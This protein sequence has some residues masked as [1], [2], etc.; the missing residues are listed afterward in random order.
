[1]TLHDNWLN[2]TVEEPLEPELPI[3]DPHHHLWHRPGNNYLLNDFIHDAESGH[4]ILQTVFIEARTDYRPGG[5]EDLKPVGETEFAIAESGSEV[6]GIYVAAG[7]VG[8]ADLALGEK[9]APVLEA[10]ISAGRKRFRGIRQVTVWD[11]S[12]V[13]KVPDIP[14]GLMMDRKFREGF[15][16]LQRYDL[17]FDAWFFHSQLSEVADL[18]KSF[19][20]TPI[21]INHTGTP[22]GIGPY[23]GKREMVF[24]DWK[25]GIRDLAGC[26]N[27][28]MKLGGLG[29]IFC[30]F[31]WHNRSVPPGSVELAQAAAPYYN[32]CIEQFGVERCMFESNFPADKIS[33]SYN[34]LW[35][36]FK[37]VSQGFSDDE[38]RALFHDT[39]AEAYRLNK[40]TK[41]NMIAL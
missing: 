22:V 3:C 26:G 24:G 19:P 40:V 9:V 16:V 14:Q 27:T 25:H 4:N 34:I 20:D 36:A 35:N 37:R 23:E 31:D 15:A 21:I 13:L 5:P 1:M 6:T 12:P 33:Y 29:M 10:H 7:I 30:G 28:F 38:R 17:S 18:A 41:R 39:A 8:Q 32:Y 11:A 2:L